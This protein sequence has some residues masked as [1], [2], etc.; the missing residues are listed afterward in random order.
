MDSLAADL[1]DAV[2]S[3]RRAPGATAVA[4]LTLG[5]GLGA[6]VALFSVAEPLLVSP[7]PLPASEQLV[8]VWQTQPGNATRWVAPANFVDWRAQSRSFSGMAAYRSTEKALVG[9]GEPQR[10]RVATVS[11]NFFEVLGRGTARG[12]GFAREEPPEPREAVVSDAFWRASLNGDASALGREVTLDGESLVV[13][14][15]LEPGFSLPAGAEIWTRARRD[16]PEAGINLPGVDHTQ[17][18]DG[19]FLSVLGRLQDGVPLSQAR[20]EMTLIGDRLRAAY[21]DANADTGV[22]LVPL[23]EQLVGATRRLLLL[24]AGVV[25]F[26]L[27]IACVNLANLTV[28]RAVRRE[29]ELAVRVA[30][31]A[32]RARLVRQ[33]LTE[34]LVLA[35]LGGLLGLG[36]ALVVRPLLAS[37][38][39]AGLPAV[40]EQG[41][42]TTLIAFASLAAVL[43]ALLSGLAPALQASAGD[44][45]RS[46]RAG[47]R[48]AGSDPRRDRLRASLVTVQVALAVVLVAGASLLGR[49]VWRLQHA[50]LGFEDRGALSLEVSVP[51]GS[52][53]SRADM[54]VLHTRVIERLQALPGIAGVGAIHA[55]PLTD[56]GW[57]AN[58]RVEGRTFVANEAPDV[59]WRVVSDRYFD[60]MQVPLLRGRRFSAGDGAEAPPVALVNETLARVLWPDEDPLGRRIGTGLDGEAALATV[61]GVVGDT[62]QTAPR[63]PAR[64]EMYRPLT[65]ETRYSASTMSLVIR[66]ADAPLAAV[67]AVRSAIWDID[68]TLPITKVQPLT[69]LALLSMARER[70]TGGLLALFGGIALF[71][72]ALGLYG[73]L[74]CLV[75]ERL[76]EF[77]VRVALGASP[78][79]VTRLVLRRAMALVAA[80]AGFGLL[81][82]LALS[83]TL[84]GLLFEVAPNDPMTHAAVVATLLTVGAL[85]AWLP[86]RRATRVDPILSL[87]ED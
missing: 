36:L 4:V 32:G 80:G 38:M 5:V 25:A 72:A 73:V 42:S 41:S 27:L 56:A 37:L 60:V 20:A 50:P 28:A 48:G 71:L 59:S 85:A 67:P 82:A 83:G 86:A 68:P 69:D 53:R 35:L 78:G 12:R 76:R 19:R 6:N 17:I 54:R 18:R 10:V 21:P 62:P 46:L 61:V 44:L 63:I 39:P 65:Q 23:Q 81:G 31:G 11:G 45:A 22:N 70:V 29:R 34:S 49:S 30:L 33:M 47:S 26:V 9:R 51:S 66:T 43:A 7:L 84:S 1:R 13:V 24:L 87:K 16:V 14:G 55:L 57:S 75:S 64:P 52:G 8:Q 40:V 79:Q 2:R 15:V 77:A 74:S 3:L 58:V